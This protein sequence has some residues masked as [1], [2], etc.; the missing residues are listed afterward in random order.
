MQEIPEV[1]KKLLELVNELSGYTDMTTIPV[2]RQAASHMR[3]HW[4]LSVRYYPSQLKHGIEFE[5][6]WNDPSDINLERI[7]IYRLARQILES[8]MTGIRT[9]FV[10]FREEQAALSAAE[11]NTICNNLIT[12]H[13]INKY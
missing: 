13:G 4:V 6:I 10:L 8:H 3:A 12:R 11:L 7:S 9:G 5:V 1:P 2:F